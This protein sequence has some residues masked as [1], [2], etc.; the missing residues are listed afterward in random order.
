M[1]NGDGPTVRASYPPATSS[2]RAQHASQA[3]RDS[4]I[5]CKGQE[6]FDLGRILNRPESDV[7]TSRNRQTVVVSQ[8]SPEETE[9][10]EG[11][12][13]F[14]GDESADGTSEI[15]AMILRTIS[16]TVEST[17]EGSLAEGDIEA[18]TIDDK[19]DSG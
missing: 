12:L 19:E 7:A 17:R 16:V 8:A 3:S 2:N 1:T 15:P 4:K 5:T 6:L 13:Y 14:G 9:L 10:K 18:Q 11:S